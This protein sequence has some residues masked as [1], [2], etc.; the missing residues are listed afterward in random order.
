MAG[1]WMLIL[2]ATTVSQGGEKKIPLPTKPCS[3]HEFFRINA[4]HLQW[5]KARV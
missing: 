5:L 2:E 1:H 4:L 3:V